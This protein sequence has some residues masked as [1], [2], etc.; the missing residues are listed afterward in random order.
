[1]WDFWF[2][3]AASLLR[4]LCLVSS[5]IVLSQQN[6]R[7]PRR[8][9]PIKRPIKGR[10]WREVILDC[11]ALLHSVIGLEKS[12]HH[13][14][15]SNTKLEPI[16]TC[17]WSLAFSRASSRLP[18]FT[19]FLLVNDDVNLSSVTRVFPRFKQIACFY[20]E[21]WLVNDDVNLSSDR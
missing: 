2:V 20:F 14:N 13:N 4:S 10:E 16:S 5:Q 21:F 11:L 9:L 7:S 12:R 8:V 3:V 15:W 19:L 17:N 6:A 18:V 1:M